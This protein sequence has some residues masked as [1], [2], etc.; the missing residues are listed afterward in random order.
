[1]MAANPHRGEAM[2]ALPS[3]ARL[4]RPTFA[5]LAVVDA[6]RGGLFAL[7]ERAAEG[8]ASLADIES[9]LWHCAVAKTAGES[10]AAFGDALLEAGLA[11]I[12]PAFRAV[13]EAA[14]R[15]QG[16]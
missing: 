13:L 11:H 10:R 4:L 1:M 8:N 3:G 2:L 15:G 7:V 14:L 5:S 9:V 6:E 16:A 12:T